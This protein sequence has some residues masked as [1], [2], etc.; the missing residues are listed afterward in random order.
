MPRPPLTRD[1][2]VTVGVA[3]VSEMGLASLN[4]RAVA[5]R[6]N[7][8]TMGVQRTIGQTEL[9]AAVV[10]QILATMP[11]MPPR[12][13]WQRR[14]RSWASVTRLWLMEY[15]GLARH[16]LNH[17]WDCEPALD[18][19]EELVEL[20]AAAGLRAQPAVRAGRTIFWYVLYSTEV[21][22]TTRT[23]FGADLAG[24]PVR[25]SPVRWPMQAAHHGDDANDSALAQ[26][27]AGVD[28]LLAGVERQADRREVGT[29]NRVV[30]AMG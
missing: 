19:L 30:G 10:E 4:L 13:T 12:G 1:R 18:R 8:T 26:F 16:L 21:D 28:L 9:I 2:I 6:V 7:A 27:T 17:R 14:L 15:P 25:A 29:S 5:R 23:V 11:S 22:Q 3:I 20:L 24:D